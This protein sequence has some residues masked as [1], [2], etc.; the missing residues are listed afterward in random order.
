MKIKN[1]T[2]LDFITSFRGKDKELARNIIKCFTEGN[3]YHFAVILEELYPG[4]FI[5]YDI[6][7]G[8]FLY[9]YNGLDYDINGIN[10]DFKHIF[11][12]NWIKYNDPLLYNRL[13]RDCVY[14]QEVEY[15]EN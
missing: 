4:G 5:V 8:H 10:K 7:N 14:K 6:L 3:C 1:P 13:L 11:T 12:L 9:E 2:I 15:E